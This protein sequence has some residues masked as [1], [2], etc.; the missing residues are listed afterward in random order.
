MCRRTWRA[1]RFD[2]SG[3]NTAGASNGGDGINIFI[4]NNTRY[5]GAGGGGIRLGTAGTG[6]NFGGANGS[7]ISAFPTAGSQ[8]GAGGGGSGGN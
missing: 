3:I 6:G 5:G 1:G 7:V 2:F 4:P 8:Y